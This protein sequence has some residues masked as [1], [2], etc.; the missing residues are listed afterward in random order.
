MLFPLE[1]GLCDSD[2]SLARC[3]PLL[4]ACAH[5]PQGPRAPGETTGCL[6]D[7]LSMGHWEATENRVKKSVSSQAVMGMYSDI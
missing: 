1:K 7:G 4:H 3:L 6:R 2:V 5:S